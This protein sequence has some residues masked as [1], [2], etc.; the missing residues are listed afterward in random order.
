MR[1][2]PTPSRSC[3]RSPRRRSAAPRGLQGGERARSTGRRP[4]HDVRAGRRRRRSS[5]AAS[6]TATSCRRHQRLYQALGHGPGRA[7]T[8][9]RRA[10]T[11]IRATARRSPT[12]SASPKSKSTSRP[13]NTRSSSSP[14]IADVGTVINPRSLQGQTFGGAMLGIGHAISQKWVYDQHYGVPLAKRF[15]YNRP[16]TILDKPIEMKFAARQHPGSRNAGRRARHRRASGRRGLRRGDERDCR[17]SRRRN[18]PA[19][20]GHARRDPERARKWR[21][22]NTRGPHG[23]HRDFVICNSRLA[24]C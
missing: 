14:L 13:A 1:Q 5:S 17:G 15:H 12:R 20:S 19:H 21:A 22:E 7:G 4:Q 24:A 3:R 9:G 16:P 23:P 11:T 10:R 6:T 8:D 2:P 18:L